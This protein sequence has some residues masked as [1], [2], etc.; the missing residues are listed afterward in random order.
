MFARR[1]RIFCETES[2]LVQRQ[3][4]CSLYDCAVL[5]LAAW[6]SPTLGHTEYQLETLA[7][8][9]SVFRQAPGVF[10]CVCVCVCVYQPVIATAD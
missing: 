1:L 9:C 4:R 6:L 3:M 7:I 2:C 10:V 8:Y 5:V